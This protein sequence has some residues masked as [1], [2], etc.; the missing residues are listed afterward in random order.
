V[1]STSWVTTTAEGESWIGANGISMPGNVPLPSGEYRVVL[2]DA[3]GETVEDTFTV[4]ERTKSAAD[5]SYPSARVAN[6]KI[7]ITGEST[8]YEVWAYGRS[9]RFAASVPAQGASPLVDVA[10]VAQASPALATGFSFRVFSWDE[11]DGYGVLSEPY[12]SGSLS[13]R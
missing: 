1:D 4:A 10:T 12:Q 2:Q 3:G 11:K 6:G 7:R 5:A 8:S 13:G 9:G